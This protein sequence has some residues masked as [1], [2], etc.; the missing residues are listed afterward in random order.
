[1]ITQIFD[2]VVGVTRSVDRARSSPRRQSA[3]VLVARLTFVVLNVRLTAV[4]LDEV[5]DLIEAKM[6]RVVQRGIA[7][8]VLRVGIGAV[9]DEKFHATSL[10]ILARHSEWSVPHLVSSVDRHALCEERFHLTIPSMA[11]VREQIANF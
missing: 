8:L 10:T 2:A 7:A 1:M 9:S 11:R 5:G 4:T 6:K 3:D